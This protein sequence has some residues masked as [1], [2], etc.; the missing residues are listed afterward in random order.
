MKPVFVPSRWCS[1]KPYQSYVEGKEGVR[2]R[3]GYAQSIRQ[4]EAPFFCIVRHWFIWLTLGRI[5]DLTE[6]TLLNGRR[7]GR[8]WCC[9]LRMRLCSRNGLLH[10][11]RHGLHSINY[12]SMNERQRLQPTKDVVPHSQPFAKLQVLVHGC[13]SGARYLR[14][15][16]YA[17]GIG[18]A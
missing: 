5:C 6:Q 7:R 3:K 9:W 12:L 16:Q 1:S 4:L 14:R 8:L 15:C 18:L 10:G 11:D 2:E 13:T 17:S